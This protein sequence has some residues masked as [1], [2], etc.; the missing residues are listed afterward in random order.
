L[1][2]KDTAGSLTELLL[3]EREEQDK[4]YEEFQALKE[5]ALNR[6]CCGCDTNASHSEHLCLH[7]GLKVMPGCFH[8]STDVK[9]RIPR[10]FLCKGCYEK[11]APE[12][13][14]P[15][16]RELRKKSKESMIEQGEKM[17]RTATSQAT[18][19]RKPIG[20]GTVVRIKVDRVDRGKLDP[21]SV[22]GVVCEVTEHDNYRIACN[23]GVLKDC[24]GRGRFQI[25]MIKKAEHYDLQ[26]ALESWQ[27]KKRISIREALAAISMMGGQGCFFCNC[28]GKC[29]TNICNCRKNKK[30]CNSKCHP[31]NTCCLNS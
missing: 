31:R 14:T 17:R 16:R 12:D 30:Q 22:P 6:C 20:V 15:K 1:E 28:K 26:D 7:S 27:T 4:R 23:G 9:D 11:V 24:L 19:V 5:Y 3:M 8:E 10:A 25:E 2:E 13:G 21:H 29:D 18:G